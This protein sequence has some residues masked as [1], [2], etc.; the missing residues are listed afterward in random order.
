[1]TYHKSTCIVWV[2]QFTTTL[3]N[4]LTENFVKLILISY[5]YFCLLL[6]LYK[7][8]SVFFFWFYRSPTWTR[9]EIFFNRFLHPSILKMTVISYISDLIVFP[10]YRVFGRDLSSV[11]I[12]VSSVRINSV[13]EPV[14]ASSFAFLLTTPVELMKA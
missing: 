11:T 2:L 7:C 3:L 8:K 1:M 10:K 14:L 6:L 5:A 12:I 9:C 13:S 4:S